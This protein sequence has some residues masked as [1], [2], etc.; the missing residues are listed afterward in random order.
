MKTRGSSPR[1]LAVALATGL[2]L[3]LGGCGNAAQERAFAH[4]R[5]REDLVTAETAP[6]I[7]QEY[8]Q[9][10]ALDPGSTWAK[11]AATRIAAVETR[12]RAEEQRKAVFQE[13]GVD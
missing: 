9:V 8:H 6:G 5:Q 12:V 7:I 4:T 1:W 11:E 13:H 10:I 2:G 3:G